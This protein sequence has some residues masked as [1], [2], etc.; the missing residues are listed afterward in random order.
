[1]CTFSLRVGTAVGALDLN[2]LTIGSSSDGFSL[3]GC[4]GSYLQKDITR[5]TSIYER[6]VTKIEEEKIGTKMKEHGG[7]LARRRS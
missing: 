2:P 1:M 6:L 4:N 3:P 7:N 5:S